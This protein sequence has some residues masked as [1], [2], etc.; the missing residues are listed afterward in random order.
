MIQFGHHFRSGKIQCHMV[1]AVCECVLR[2]VSLKCGAV[3]R[4][5][6]VHV[7]ISENGGVESSNELRTC[8]HFESLTSSVGP[9]L[10]VLTSSD[11]V[12]FRSKQTFKADICYLSP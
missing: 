6:Y 4:L 2:F 5:L 12:T 10:R 1:S 7:E 3:Y 8:D 9:P 11:L